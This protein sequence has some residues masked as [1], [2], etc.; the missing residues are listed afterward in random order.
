MMIKDKVVVI[1][2]ASS[3]IGAAT[4]KRLAQAGAKVVLGA[5]H[6]DKL[7]KLSQEIKNDGGTAAYL[8]TDVTKRE[9]NQAL[10]DFAKQQFGQVDAI[11]LNAGIMPS[12][13]LD[14]LK[15]DDWE[16]TIDINLKGVLYGIAAVLPVFKEQ[17]HGQVIATSSVAGLKTYPGYAAY[18]AS[19]WGVR[20][21]M[22][23]LRQE[24]AQSTA[25]I[26]TTTIYP[27]AVHSNL[28][29]GIPD[30]A[31]Q[32]GE[33]AVRSQTELA[34]DEV[35][36]AVEYVIDAPEGTVLQEMTI[37]PLNQNW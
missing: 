10:V 28:I 27:A 17:G 13:R 15:V 18:C 20:A 35:A 2:G 16:K 21:V 3:G 23:T 32:Q 19:K 31:I 25:N 29:N 9:D 12:S 6:E 26:R 7:A 11:F 34:A 8:A 1:T 4:A 24:T 30:P 5:R 14:E 33:L 37:A 22:D 36:K